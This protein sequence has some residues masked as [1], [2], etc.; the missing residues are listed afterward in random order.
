MYALL[1]ALM[2]FISLPA[3]ADDPK[4]TEDRH[5]MVTDIQLMDPCKRLE[6]KA[7]KGWAKAIENKEKIAKGCTMAKY[8][9]QIAQKNFS[10]ILDAYQAI[11]KRCERGEKLSMRDI[12]E[13]PEFSPKG[14]GMF[15]CFG[16]QA[17]D[18]KEI[19]E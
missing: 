6:H 2:V 17:P 15:C 19:K 3:L 18:L 14:N 4:H 13:L 9:C 1:S 7:Q 16:F 10:P 12:N 8:N 11:M 5:A